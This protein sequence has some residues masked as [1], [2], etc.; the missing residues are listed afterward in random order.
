[1]GL[2]TGFEPE[3]YFGPNNEVLFYALDTFDAPKG[4]AVYQVLSR[5]ETIEQIPG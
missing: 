4:T 2:V 3:V 1:M 5:Q